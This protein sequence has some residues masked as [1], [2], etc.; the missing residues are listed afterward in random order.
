VAEQEVSHLL[1]VEPDTALMAMIT[2]YFA[3]EGFQ[4]AT[5]HTGEEALQ[6]ALKQR[7]R[8]ILMETQLPDRAGLSVF[9]DL[10][11]YPRTGHIPVIFLAGGTEIFLQNQILEEGGHD[12]I[13]KPF[14]I[15]ELGLRIKN[16]LRTSNQDQ[17][18]K[19]HILTRL[20]TGE[21]VARAIE[22]TAWQDNFYMINLS[23]KG[24]DT[25]KDLN[26]F[27]SANEVIVFAANEISDV[28]V[29]FGEPEDFV[30]HLDEASFIVITNREHGS[31]IQQEIHRRLNNHLPQFHSFIERDRGYVEVPD[32]NGKVQQQALMSVQSTEKQSK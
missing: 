28:V 10:R 9:R 21:G 17:G 7:P 23:I 8:V 27:V 31:Q 5:A 16:A 13:Q 1:I 15:A 14:D 29:E 18:I 3:E 25:F 12:V 11:R 30:G 22:S 32:N 24:F 2:A 4:F 20:P 19:T 6:I 26:G